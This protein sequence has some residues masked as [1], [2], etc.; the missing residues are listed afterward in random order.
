MRFRAYVDGAA[1]N[2]PGPAGAG[3]YIESDGTRPVEE[4]FE[5]LGSTTNNVAEYRALILALRRA[6]ELRADE[7][8]IF[9]DSR[10][11]VEQ[12]NGRF[13]VKAAHLKLLL[14]EAVQ[15][16]KRFRKFSVTHVRRENNIEADRLANQ[17]ADISEISL[18]P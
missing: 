15:R 1:R 11:M 2:N 12:M 13:R 18:R 14:S 8:E 5:A 17:G 10:L 3:V 4:L 6:E 9:S 7:V 16:A